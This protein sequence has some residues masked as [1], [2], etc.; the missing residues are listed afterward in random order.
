[1]YDFYLF[2]C[3]IRDCL[4][5]SEMSIYVSVWCSKAGDRSLAFVVAHEITHSWM[6]NLVTNRNWEHFWFVQ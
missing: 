3:Y 1:M 4:Q 5:I 6:G 2:S